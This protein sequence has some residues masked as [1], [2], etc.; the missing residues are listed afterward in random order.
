MG[1]DLVL[2]EKE[3]DLNEYVDGGDGIYSVRQVD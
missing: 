3:I 2:T 1:K